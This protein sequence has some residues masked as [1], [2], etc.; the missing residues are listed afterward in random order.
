MPELAEAPTGCVFA[1]RCPEVMAICCQEP[2]L[3]ELSPTQ[4]AKCWLYAERGG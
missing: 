4:S 1:D 2:P 3:S